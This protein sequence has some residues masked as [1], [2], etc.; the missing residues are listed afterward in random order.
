MNRDI[1]GGTWKQLSGKVQTQWGRFIGDHL[2]VIAGKRQQAF[3]IIRS[4]TLRGAAPTR[5]TARSMSLV[6]TAVRDLPPTVSVLTTSRHEN[7]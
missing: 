7:D 3:G 5:H 4:K 1:V 2:G 6:L